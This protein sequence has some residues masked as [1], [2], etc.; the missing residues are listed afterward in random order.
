[1]SDVSL[2]DLPAAEA[3]AAIAAGSLDAASCSTT[4]RARARPIVRRADKA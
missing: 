3:A 4:Y 2:L 1:M